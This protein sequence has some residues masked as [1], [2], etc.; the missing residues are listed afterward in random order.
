M[1]EK[2]DKK[3]IILNRIE[4]RMKELQDQYKAKYPSELPN[5]F[6]M[7]LLQLVMN[8]CD[9]NTI[10]FSILNTAANVYLNRQIEYEE[11]TQK[12]AESRVN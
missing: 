1:C 8:Y 2:C 6:L 10:T 12:L 11:E 5:E 9:E 3:N 7:V 4:P